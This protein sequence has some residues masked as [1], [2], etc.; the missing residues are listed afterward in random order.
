[1]RHA[2]LS[3][4]TAYF[5]SYALRPKAR[6]T[7]PKMIASCFLTGLLWLSGSNLLDGSSSASF[8]LHSL[9]LAVGQPQTNSASGSSPVR[10]QKWTSA[11]SGWLY[12]VD[13]WVREPQVLLVNPH[14]GAVRGVI[15]T[16]YDPDLELSPDGRLLYI[17]SGHSWLSV[18]DS[19][20]G[21]ILREVEFPDRQ[22]YKVMPWSSGMAI[23]PSG[24]WLYIRRM[25]PG[26]IGEDKHTV[27]IFDT[28]TQRFLDKMISTPNCGVG[29]MVPGPEENVLK[30]LCRNT[31]D[32]RTLQLSSDGTILS[33]SEAAL[34]VRPADPG[35]KVAGERPVKSILSV[36]S[37]SRT[38][39][40]AD[41]TIWRADNAGRNPVQMV[42]IQSDRSIPFRHW[43]VSKAGDTIFIGSSPSAQAADGGIDR[44]HVISTTNWSEV[45][46]IDSGIPLWSLTLSNDDKYLYGSSG[47]KNQAVIIV[48][49][50]TYKQTRVLKPIGNSPSLIRIAP[51]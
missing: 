19:F 51:D 15:Q 26:P 24:K 36:D 23:S 10:I 44:I 3:K 1:M 34:R 43:P 38:T 20:E 14:G 40:L 46:T 32:I 13:C 28:Q 21:K 6:P 4:F 22:M 48:D 17:A 27:S 49:L 41:G 37:L 9:L 8:V 35:P 25:Q 50:D 33:Q 29:Q 47:R 16:G 7:I 18:I 45:G 30:V 42:T 2:V 31:D 11:Q 12:V 5:K 39:I